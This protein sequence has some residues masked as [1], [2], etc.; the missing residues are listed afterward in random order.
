MYSPSNEIQ[1]FQ[2]LFLYVIIMYVKHLFLPYIFVSAAVL[3]PYYIGWCILVPCL[4]FQI[5]FDLFQN[6]TSHIWSSWSYFW[7]ALLL[8]HELSTANT[9]YKKGFLIWSDENVFFGRTYYSCF[10]PRNSVASSEI[11]FW[12]SSACI[13][14]MPILWMN[15]FTNNKKYYQLSMEKYFNKQ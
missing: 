6:S 10:R 15:E 9:F 13:A 7:Q 5:Y 3:Y 4:L 8:M 11:F 1:L 14:F 12:V 2:V